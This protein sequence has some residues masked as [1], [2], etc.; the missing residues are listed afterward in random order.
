MAVSGT[1]LPASFITIEAGDGY[2][3]YYG[4]GDAATNAEL[5]VPEGI[6]FD[7]T[8][9]LYIADTANSVVRKVGCQREYFDRRGQ[10]S[11]GLQG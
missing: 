5:N 8:G 1:N 6:A 3:G 11:S 7:A 4:D 9:N 10:R 2:S